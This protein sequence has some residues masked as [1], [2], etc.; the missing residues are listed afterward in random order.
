MIGVLVGYEF[1]T[2]GLRLFP[3]DQAGLLC[4]L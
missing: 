3:S 1:V 2:S 4:S